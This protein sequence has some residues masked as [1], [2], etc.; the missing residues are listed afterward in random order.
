MKRKF[1]LLKDLP[2]AKAGSIYEQISQW[3]TNYQIKGADYH[4]WWD[5]SFIEKHP[6][7][8]EEVFEVQYTE[9]DMVEFASYHALHNNW[10][11]SNLEIWKNLKNK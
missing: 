4:I 9:K 2:D 5:I 10:A 7:W 8:F 6:D 1:K 3:G 11:S